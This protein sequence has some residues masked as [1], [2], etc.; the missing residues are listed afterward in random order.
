MYYTDFLFR[1]KK[2]MVYYLI[3]YYSSVL[4][5]QTKMCSSNVVLASTTLSSAALSAIELVI[6]PNVWCI[7]VLCTTRIPV[8]KGVHVSNKIHSIFLWG[9]GEKRL[10]NEACQNR[11]T[12]KRMLHRRLV[13]FAASNDVPYVFLSAFFSLTFEI[14]RYTRICAICIR[15]TCNTIS[16]IYISDGLAYFKR[17]KVWNNVT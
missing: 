15:S 3:I 11:R 5:P 9:V 6:F 17:R 2:H 1:P 16:C 10:P 13:A 7:R 14:S 4:N 8:C 12:N